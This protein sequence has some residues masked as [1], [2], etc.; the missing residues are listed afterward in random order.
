MILVQFP[1]CTGSWGTPGKACIFY[2]ASQIFYLMD[3]AFQ[4]LDDSRYI[5]IY[6]VVF[7][8]GKIIMPEETRTVYSGVFVVRATEFFARE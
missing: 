2:G 4:G 3:G 8:L 6:L 1:P 7:S 5:Y